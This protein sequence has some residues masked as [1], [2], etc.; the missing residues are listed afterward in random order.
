MMAHALASVG[1]AAAQA[2]YL[3]APLLVAA[4]LSGIVLR[5][6]LLPCLRRPIDGGAMLLGERLFGDGKTWR[7]A[8][9]AVV[10]SIAGVAL[11]QAARARVPSWVAVVD[12]GAVAPVGLG[13]A[14][15]AGATLGELPNSFVKRR[16]GIAPGATARGWP[17][18]LFY[19]WDQVDLLTGA[20]PLLG[21]WLCPR[22]L[23]VTASFAV[24]LALH[25]LVAAIG[26]LIG[27]RTSPR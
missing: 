24:A 27:A 25:P 16:L 22:P 3:F 14:M 12:Y 23:L 9:M 5:F 8:A 13:A 2:L 4:A 21:A 20:W 19:V 15:G 1:L 7:G 6:D 11:Q 18:A 17:A 26:Y 10:G